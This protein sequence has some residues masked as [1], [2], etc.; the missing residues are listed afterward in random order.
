MNDYMPAR[1]QGPQHCKHTQRALRLY[2]HVMVA[3]MALPPNPARLLQGELTR[4]RADLRLRE[5]ADATLR[6]QAVALRAETAAASAAAAEDRRRAAAEHAKAQA[7]AA[8]LERSAR[9]ETGTSCN[10]SS[11]G[12]TTCLAAIQP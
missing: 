10:F 4:Q 2:A 5:A 8:A 12:V 1:S 3:A 9:W 6:N 7:Q 11:W